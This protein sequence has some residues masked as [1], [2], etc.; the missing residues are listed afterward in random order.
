MIRADQKIRV[1]PSCKWPL[2][3]RLTNEACV[4]AMRGAG[5][6]CQ[7][8]ACRA[9]RQWYPPRGVTNQTHGQV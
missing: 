1:G 6:L 9:W 8:E 4:I 5:L 7:C 2:R 3:C